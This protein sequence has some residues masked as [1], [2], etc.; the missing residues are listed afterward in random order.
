MNHLGSRAVRSC[1]DEPVMGR[2]ATSRQVAFFVSNLH[3]LSTPSL[4]SK[5]PGPAAVVVPLTERANNIG[6]TPTVNKKIF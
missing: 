1:S 4:F 3:L 5:N 2:V 6:K